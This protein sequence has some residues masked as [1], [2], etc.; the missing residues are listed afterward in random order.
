MPGAGLA[1][2]GDSKL[3]ARLFTL[4]KPLGKGLELQLTSAHGVWVR[5]DWQS[6]VRIDGSCGARHS[7][8]PGFGSKTPVGVVWQS[9]NVADSTEATTSPG[10][11]DEH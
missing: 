7:Q 9:R 3:R 4:R 8:D 6:T 2:W 11:L 1:L 10:T 5:N